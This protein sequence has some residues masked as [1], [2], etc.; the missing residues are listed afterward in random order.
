MV[1]YFIYCIHRWLC[2]GSDVVIV[3]LVCDAD[4]GL[5]LC[6]CVCVWYQLSVECACIDKP[7]LLL[8][9]RVHLS[10]TCAYCSCWYMFLQTACTVCGEKE[11]INKYNYYCYNSVFKKVQ[12]LFPTQY[13]IAVADLPSHLLLFRSTTALNIKDNFFD[14]TDK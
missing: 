6:A 1:A 13:A 5:T 14:W 2:V 4:I 8:P 10:C 9:P 7:C 12:R 3:L 11:P